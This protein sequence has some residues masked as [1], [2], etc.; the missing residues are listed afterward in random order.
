MVSLRAINYSLGQSSLDE[1]MPKVVNLE[2]FAA[3]LIG[4]R[5][6]K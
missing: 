3:P 2:R 1:L 6:D 4:G 5:E